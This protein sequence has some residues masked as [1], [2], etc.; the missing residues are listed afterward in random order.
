MDCKDR[1]IENLLSPAFYDDIYAL[2]KNEIDYSRFQNKTILI[3][4]AAGLIGKYLVL[5]LLCANDLYDYHIS[6]IALVHSKKKASMVLG[7]AVNREDI[8]IIEADVCNLP[9]DLP[10]ANYVIHAASPAS[11]IQ[12]REN[13]V[14]T[15]TTNTVGTYSVLE[16]AHLNQ[17][18]SIVCCSSLKVYGQF[19]D[20]R[21]ILNEEANGILDFTNYLNCYAE[22]KR[23][24]EMLC[25]SYF[26]QYHLPVKL[27]RPSYI[28][29][30]CSL[31]DDR[32]WAQFIANVVR[33]ENILLKSNGA[34]LR[35]FCYVRDTASAIFRVLLNGENGIVY[36]IADKKSD[37]TIRQFAEL[38]V[39]A[40][41]ERKLTLSFENEKDAIEPDINSVS[42]EVLTNDKLLEL[43]WIPQ[44]DISNGVKITVSI[45]EQGFL[46]N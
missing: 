42:A 16:Y 6:V 19:N 1:T 37:I 13:P 28:Y 41:P 15:F 26:Q 14:G 20:K 18:E 44:V 36:N 45:L 7:D 25:N 8:R 21:Q 11:A 22:G 27:V 29:G 39:E 40:F 23:A 38:A 34:V 10:K 35:S 5:S 17:C 24:T 33:N 46:K 2:T 3:T 30:A 9:P 12:Y 31:D 32:V 4:G 43:G